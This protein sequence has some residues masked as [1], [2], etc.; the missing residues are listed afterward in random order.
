MVLNVA[1]VSPKG[2]FQKRP[3]VAKSA[4]TDL[5]YNLKPTGLF[6]IDGESEKKLSSTFDDLILHYDPTVKSG[7]RSKAIGIFSISFTLRTKKNQSYLVYNVL[8]GPS[9][10]TWELLF[11]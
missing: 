1:P 5:S 11:A 2:S 9:Q 6:S 4:K 3:K 8:L 7:V 10:A